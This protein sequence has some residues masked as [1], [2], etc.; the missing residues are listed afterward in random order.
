MA[1]G[2][3]P[4]F[5]GKRAPLFTKKSGGKKFLYERK[6]KWKEKE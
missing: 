1:K 6:D 4:L 3:K 5:G 2:K